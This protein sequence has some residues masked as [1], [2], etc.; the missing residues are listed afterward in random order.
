M[1]DFNIENGVL[2]KY[3]GKDADVIIPDGVTEIDWWA[4]YGCRR[5]KSVTIPD[6]VAKIGSYAFRDCS[7]LTSIT[8][9]DSVTEIGGSAF[10]GCAK[11]SE[12]HISDLAKWCDIKFDG[13]WSNPLE[14]A[15]NLYLNGEHVTDLV[16]PDG[17]TKICDRAFSD[18]SSLTSVTIPDSVTKIGKSAFGNCSCLTSVTIPDSVTK[19]DNRAFSGCIS[20]ASAMIPDSVTKIGNEA[21]SYCSGLTSVTIPDSVAKIGGYAFWNCSSLTSVTIPDSVTE[22][23]NWAFSGC[24]KLSEVHISD[25]A[26]WCDIKFDGWYSNPLEYAHNL[27]L[28]GE[29]VTDLVIPKGVT[30]IGDWAFSGFSSL[31][32]ITIL[33]GIKKI[34]QEAFSGCDKLAKV[35]ISDLAKWCSI[36]FDEGCSNP[37][38]YAHNLYLNGEHVTDLVIPDGVTKICYSAFSGCRS[39]TSVTIPDSV[40]KIGGWAFRGCSGLTSV[41]VGGSVETIEWGAFDGC[42]NLKNVT[43]KNGKDLLWLAEET[44]ICYPLCY[45]ATEEQMADAIKEAAK[46]KKDKKEAFYEAYLVS[47][48]RAAMLLAEKRKELDKYAKMRGMTADEVRDSMLSDLGLD[49][50]GCKAYDLGNMTVNVRMLSDFTF[51]VELPDGKASKSIPK[52]GA[53]EKKYEEA[54]KDFTEI[55]KSVKKIW[56]NRADTILSDFITGKKREVSYWQK[57]YTGNP[58]LRGVAS[59]IVWE[60]DGAYFTK[61]KDGTVDADGAPYE[62]GEGTVRVA[63]PMEMSAEEVSAWQKYFTDRV[64][65]Q[66]FAQIW[67][68]VYKPEDISEDRYRDCPILFFA[69][70]G[71]GKHGFDEKL[72]IPGCKVETK[73]TSEKAPNGNSVSYCNITSFRIEKY[74]RAVN[75]AIAYLDRTTVLGRIAKDDISVMDYVEGCNAA[76]ITDY[77][78]AANNAKATNVLAALLEYK[79]KNFPDATPFD[80]FT[81]D[82]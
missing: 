41:T 34:G 9:P 19:I 77:T 63:H 14:Y 65:K 50:E 59:L 81:L 75:H 5:L 78:D 71:A 73:W 58:V 11:F 26:K 74:S 33:R 66:P 48:T 2:K 29:H 1:S 23:G 61:T 53:D 57:T 42:I 55:K 36:K 60:Q 79:N 27:Y 12:V 4:F 32:S 76:Q 17:V 39:L 30:K 69:L 35:H 54:N 21:F 45:T 38:E 10:Y 18:C 6:S 8:I 28:N 37:L 20:L 31:T 44:G 52:K 3:T 80:M 62:L 24:A 16:I 82:W 47:D 49:A 43:L 56:K 68:R 72:D 64:L 67:E 7:D 15:H 51:T 40:K 13:Y 25:L 22:I 46:W 70:Q